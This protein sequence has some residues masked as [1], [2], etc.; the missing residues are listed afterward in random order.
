MSR[1]RAPRSGCGES[2]LQAL[3]SLGGI[4]A[5][6]TAHGLAGAE[7]LRGIVTG[8]LAGVTCECLQTC[9]SKPA[10]S[11]TLSA[12]RVPPQPSRTPGLERHRHAAMWQRGLHFART[13]A[14]VH[15]KWPLSMGP[16][17]ETKLGRNLLTTWRE[18]RPACEG[19]PDCRRRE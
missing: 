17:P 11:S 14:I 10:G 12:R 18:C 9:A 16:E 4:Q 6:Q 8:D 7:R 15:Q 2:G 13:G 19:F 5:C 3:E 1:P